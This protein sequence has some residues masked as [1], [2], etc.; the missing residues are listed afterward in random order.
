MRNALQAAG[1]RAQHPT[2]EITNDKRPLGPWYSESMSKTRV[3]VYVVAI[4]VLAI[5]A[6]IIWLTVFRNPVGAPGRPSQSQNTPLSTPDIKP[7]QF[8]TGLTAPVDITAPQHSTDE[9]LFVV[10]QAGKIRTIDKQGKLVA[11][12][13]LDITGKVQSGGELG[14]LGLAFHPDYAKNGYVY[15]NYTDKDLH[16][17]V[18]RYKSSPQTGV[19]DPASEK[20]IL[21]QKQ[22]YRNHNG[23]ALQFGPD[24][25]LYIAFGDGGSAGDPENRA[26]NKNEWLGKLLRI[27]INSDGPYIVPAT[28]PFVGQSGVKPEIWALGLRN[29][30]KISFD[31][32]TGDLYIAD[33]GQGDIEE[34]NIQPKKSQGG[35]NYGWRCYEGTGTFNAAGCQDKAAYTAPAFEYGHSEE[36]CSVTG[37]AVYRG[38]AEKALSGK[39]FYADFCSGHLYYAEKTNNKW[40]STL[41]EKTPYSISTFGQNKAGEIYFADHKSGIVYR[42]DDSAN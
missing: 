33:V 4:E 2:G 15:V 11:A 24:G 7:V 8:A 37:G 5:A 34:I 6:L 41:V 1:A 35:E 14:L 39:Y 27:D 25:Y 19:A 13:F 36:R 21:K 22:P 28:N 9:R 31:R 12:P 29:P 20:V 23:G 42:L 3:L 17:V 18:A 40:K 26:Q 10:E 38:A 16:T 30:W 32:T